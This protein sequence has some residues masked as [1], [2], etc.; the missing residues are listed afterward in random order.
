[1]ASTTS[2]PP[3]ENDILSHIGAW[4]FDIEENLS[5]VI[6]NIE[7]DHNDLINNFRK[8]FY[9]V[10]ISSASLTVSLASRQPSHHYHYHYHEFLLLTPPTMV[11][12]E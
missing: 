11:G 10:S 4:T 8:R 6:H 1:M 2:L 12:A 3:L 9:L 5:T 7:I